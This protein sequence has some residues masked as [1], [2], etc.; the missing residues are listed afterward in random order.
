MT[1][2]TFIVPVRHQDSAEHWDVLLKNLRETIKSIK[3]QTYYNWKCIIVANSGAVLPELPDKFEVCYVNYPPNKLY[4]KGIADESSFQ[5]A[6]RLDKGKRILSGIKHAGFT[7]YFMFVDDDDFIHRDLA[8]FVSV[9]M[10]GNGWYIQ[11]GL[12]WQDGTNY[13]LN[14]NRFYMFCGTSH[15]VRSDLLGLAGNEEDVGIEYVKRMLGSHV[16]LKNELY[17]KQ[18]PLMPLPFRGAI[19]RVGHSDTHSMSKGIAD[20][21]FSIGQISSNPLEALK[22]LFSIRILTNNIRKTYFGA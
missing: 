15:I 18:T 12:L 14:F 4:K 20:S 5:E 7:N 21:F 13:L 16:H 3:A 10:G 22:H 17:K 11:K 2:L 8:K 9:N 1:C 6:V 19:Y